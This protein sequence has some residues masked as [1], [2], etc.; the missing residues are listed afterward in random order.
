VAGAAISPILLGLVCES[1]LS[2]STTVFRHLSDRQLFQEPENIP[3]PGHFMAERYTH[4]WLARLPPSLLRHFISGCLPS[5]GGS[6][7]S[8]VAANIT[9]TNWLARMLQLSRT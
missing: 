1:R 4:A 3:C 8:I 6:F 5:F 7:A 2:W 9:P